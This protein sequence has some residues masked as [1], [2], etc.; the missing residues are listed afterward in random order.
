M[1]LAQVRHNR[2]DHNQGAELLHQA[3]DVAAGFPD[4]GRLPGMI[5]TVSRRFPADG[6]MSARRRGTV[7]RRGSS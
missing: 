5:E 6:P 7:N 3:R 2:G 1:T 4:P